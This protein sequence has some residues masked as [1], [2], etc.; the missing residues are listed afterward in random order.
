MSAVSAEHSRADEGRS[1]R[2]SALQFA[3]RLLAREAN[4]ASLS[5]LLSGL[6]SDLAVL[7]E[8]CT[9]GYLF[10]SREEAES[11]AEEF[12]AGPSCQAFLALARQLD[13][14]I[15]FGFAERSSEHLYNSCALVNPD[16]SH[17]LY[18]KRIFSTAKSSSSS[19]VIP[20]STSFRPR[21]ESGSA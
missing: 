5:Q 10:A 1:Y 19:R 20:A 18:R 21:Q 16:G 13:C 8:L 12:P 2:I 15:V 14:S 6:Q 4:L 17:H 7:P 3:P 11:V 9:C